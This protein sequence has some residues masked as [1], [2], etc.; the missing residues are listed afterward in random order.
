MPN[1]VSGTDGGRDGI[2]V[3]SFGSA[4]LG[5]SVHPFTVAGDWQKS[6]GCLAAARRYSFIFRP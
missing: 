5:P 3:F 1:Y 2:D 6:G 4:Y